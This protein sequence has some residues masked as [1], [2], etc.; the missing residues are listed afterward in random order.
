MRLYKLIIAGHVLL[1]KSLR[2]II[3]NRPEQLVRPFSTDNSAEGR[4]DERL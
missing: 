1:Q 4:G 3:S 2:G